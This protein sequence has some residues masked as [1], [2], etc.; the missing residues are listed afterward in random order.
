VKK[1]TLLYIVALLFTSVVWGAVSDIVV[2]QRAGGNQRFVQRVVTGTANTYKPVGFSSDGTFEA[3]S[4]IRGA[5]LGTPDGL[6]NIDIT[7]NGTIR[8]TANGTNSI[9][10]STRKLFNSSGTE[11][12]DWNSN[13]LQG[14]WIVGGSFKVG[15]K[16]VTGN[17]LATNAINTSVEL[18]TKTVSANTTFTFSATPAV[19][20]VFDLDVK[21]SGGSEITITI[22]SSKDAST[23]ASITSLNLIAT[24]GR[25]VLSWRYDGTDYI[26]TRVG[27][28]AETVFP[29]TTNVGF[30][31]FNASN[32][33]IVTATNFVGDGSAITDLNAAELVGTIPSLSTGLLTTQ[34]A[35]A[36]TPVAGVSNVIVTDNGDTTITLNDATE[37]LTYSN[38]PPDGTRFEY[39][40]TGQATDTTVNIPETYSNALGNLRSTF[41][42][43]ALK[44]ANIVV[45]REAGRYVMWGDPVTIT[46]YPA[47]TTP[48]V[49]G[50]LEVDQNGS[51]RSTLGQIKAL[52]LDTPVLTGGASV[53]GILTATTFSGSGDDLTNLPAD[54][55]VGTLPDLGTGILTTSSSKKI[56]PVA[57]VSN[58]INTA[59]GE[60]T[61]ALDATTETLSYSATPSTGT[62]FSYTLEGHSAASVVTIPSTYSFALGGFRTSFTAPA[63]KPT[64]ITVRRDAGRYI[65]WGDPV[66]IG[67][68]SNNLSPTTAAKLE[69]DQGSGSEYITLNQV[70]T[71][72]STSPTFTGIVT[73]SGATAN[74]A[75]AMAANAIDVT[76][77]L[78]TKTISANTTFTFTGTPVTNQWFGLYVKNTGG[79]AVIVTFPN[80]KDSVSGASITTSTVT[81][82]T[83]R[84]HLYWRWDGTE[85]IIYRGTGD[86]TLLS[87]DQNIQ[88]TLTA[89]TFSGEGTFL[90]NI[91]GSAL[92]GPIPDI[93]VDTLTTDNV[94]VIVP[95]AISSGTIDVTK[96]WSYKTLTSNLT[97]SFSDTPANGT[98][99]WVEFICDSVARQITLP[100]AVYS[101]E[102]GS[103]VIDFTVQANTRP[104][105]SFIKLAD[106][107]RAQ[108]IPTQISDLA[109]VNSPD[110][111]ASIEIDQGTGSRRTTLA[112]IKTALSL[113]TSRT[114]T[115][116]TP[117]T[118]TPLSPTWTGP[119]HTVYYGATGTINLP[120]ASAYADKGII[121]YNTGSFT[122]TV[123]ASGSEVIVR[124]GAV[125]TGGVSFTLSTGAG[126]FV[127]LISDGIRW[128]TLEYKGTLTQGS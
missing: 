3:I 34:K 64:S 92:N 55:I 117:S 4:Q 81:A 93:E 39:T 22:P 63:S 119:S 107:W 65:M 128:I 99:L 78:N 115:H 89:T 106:G 2:G 96:G 16:I 88:G 24:T 84:Q 28:G 53:Q 32:I 61:I 36:V 58:A 9:N 86:G 5:T 67:D 42:V 77:E 105:I 30:G 91:P 19:G 13:I 52:M 90:D 100:T 20:Q 72:T 51:T 108:G 48:T 40:L 37:T 74:T 126:N 11:T 95:T 110:T 14:N 68:L 121:I 56:L 103:Q 18:N 73:N 101:D 29:L 26:L 124:D 46:D 47:N 82:T 125:Q 111:T 60:T 57:G 70:K 94:R 112:N 54:Q 104:L 12:F 97:I 116:A 75:A 98:I 114:G 23:G 127:N 49:D 21:N 8:I 76:Q 33:G 38:T 31:G 122:I 69:I 10:T 17:A 62:Y 25:K 45:K 113:D 79:T 59:N 27:S 102:R 35:R 80:S 109:A 123:D 118:T 87:G 66:D 15:S 71:L 120:A 44:N 6:S 1:I 50:I 41:T 7:T 43:P 85:Y 83:G